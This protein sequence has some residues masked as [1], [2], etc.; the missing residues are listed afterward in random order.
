KAERAA[1]LKTLAAAT[2]EADLQKRVESYDISLALN[3]IG[4]L[5]QLLSSEYWEAKD[6]DVVTPEDVA[7]LD[8]LRQACELVL[9][10]L[11]SEFMA[12]FE[13]AP[14][15][16]TTVENVVRCQKRAAGVPA[17]VAE[18][19]AIVKLTAHPAPAKTDPVAPA[20][21]PIQEPPAV[22]A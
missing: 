9:S 15:D 3:A 19:L 12:Q 1:F 2:L 20:A 7:Q 22:D 4:Y 5:E 6:G 11:I 16:A 21:T 10:F 17:K 13:D 8:M 18:L 14:T